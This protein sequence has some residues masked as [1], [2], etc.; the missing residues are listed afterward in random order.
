M[1]QNS[2][3]IIGGAVIVDEV[4][5]RWARAHNCIIQNQ[6]LAIHINFILYFTPYFTPYFTLYFT[7]YFIPNFTLHF[8][9]ELIPYIALHFIPIIARSTIK[10]QLTCHSILL[11]PSLRQ[12]TEL[13]NTMKTHRETDN[14][15]YGSQNIFR[16]LFHEVCRKEIILK[17][18]YSHN[19]IK[20]YLERLQNNIA[21]N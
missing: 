18:K 20:K 13:S 5:T 11:I 17:T 12:Q 15:G 19:I 6:L 21:Y 2:K 7:L 8:I 16:R 4:Q 9:P 1:P 10:K 3:S 14:K